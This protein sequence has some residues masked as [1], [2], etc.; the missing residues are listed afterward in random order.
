MNDKSHGELHSF[1]IVINMTT[2]MTLSSE[3]SMKIISWHPVTRLQMEKRAAQHA[4]ASMSQGMFHGVGIADYFCNKTA[5]SSVSTKIVG[6]ISSTFEFIVHFAVS[7]KISCFRNHHHSAQL[8]TFCLQEL[9]IF[10]IN[11][12]WSSSGLISSSS[13]LRK[14]RSIWNRPSSFFNGF[15]SSGIW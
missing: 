11:Y 13:V 12:C 2:N 14:L 15:S 9:W 5:R 1:V 7:P 3:N 8:S 6:S 4:C 10:L